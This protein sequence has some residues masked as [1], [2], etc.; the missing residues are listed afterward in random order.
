MNWI[1]TRI[2]S[3]DDSIKQSIVDTYH[4]SHSR[5]RGNHWMN[6]DN[7][8]TLWML[9]DDRG[10]CR[11][12]RHFPATN[13]VVEVTTSITGRLRSEREFPRLSAA[14]RWEDVIDNLLNAVHVDFEGK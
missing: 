14:R 8:D 5:I 4:L 7:G 1:N 9:H 3:S 13:I 2:D 6:L 12:F 10:T 11:F